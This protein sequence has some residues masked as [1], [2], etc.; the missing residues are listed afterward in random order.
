MQGMIHIQQHPDSNIL[1]TRAIKTLDKEDYERMLPA[2]ENIIRTF[3]KL[4]WYFEME[5]FAGWT[6]TAAWADLKFDFK[7]ANDIEKI[8]LVGD[9]DWEKWLS[10]LMQPFTA[11]E[12]RFFKTAQREAAW[13]WIQQ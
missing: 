9:E 4:R 3:G 2:A 1:R 6:P 8:A 7:H 11:A 10:R 13:Q 5:D 12:V